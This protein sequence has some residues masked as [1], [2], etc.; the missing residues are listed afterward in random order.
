[1]DNN[2]G[3]DREYGLTWV[4]K[5]LRS[6][7]GVFSSLLLLGGSS[8]TQITIFSHDDRINRCAVRNAELQDPYLLAAPSSSQ[9][10][11]SFLD[12]ERIFREEPL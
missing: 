11:V 3:Q 5:R 10:K 6:A 4:C 12:F 2:Y 8:S 1:M 7:V 9:N